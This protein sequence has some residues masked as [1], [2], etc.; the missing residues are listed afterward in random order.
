MGKYASILTREVGIVHSQ[1][2]WEIY[3]AIF[4]LRGAAELAEDFFKPE[5]MEDQQTLISIEM[6]PLGVVTAIIPW[7]VPLAIAMSKIAPI[8]VTGN[9]VVIKPSPNAFMAVS[10][11]LKE[12]SRQWLNSQFH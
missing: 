3:G 11:A 12:M 8:L 4:C 2:I 6:V 7:N 1:S 5:V 10:M 9:T